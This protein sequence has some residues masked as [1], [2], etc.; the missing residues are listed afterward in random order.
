VAIL[1]ISWGAI[2]SFFLGPFVWGLFTKQVNRT[3]ALASGLGG[4]AVCLGMYFLGYPSPQAGT[5]GMLASLALNPLFSMVARPR[6]K[7]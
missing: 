4:L 3:G 5:F 1:G 7:L 6:L 2:G